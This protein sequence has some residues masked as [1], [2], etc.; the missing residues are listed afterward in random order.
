M[1]FLAGTA[2]GAYIAAHAVAIFFTAASLFV[3]YAMRPGKPKT[4]SGA[5]TDPARGIKL[6]T[7]ETSAPV[8]VLY[9][10]NKIGGNDVFIETVGTDN[11]AVWIVQGMGE[12][13]I[14]GVQT[15][16]LNDKL[17]TEYGSL[18]DYWEHLGTSDQT[19]DA[20]LT[21]AIAKFTDPMR[22]AAYLV[23]KLQFDADYFQGLPERQV[24]VRGRKLYDFRDESTAYSTNHVL[25]LYDYMTNTRYGLGIAAAKIDTDSWE[26]V[27]N[28]IDAKGW[29][30]HYAVTADMT[31][32]DVIDT[33]LTHF[34][35]EM[36][37]WDGKYYLRYADLNE[38]AIAMTIDDEQIA[39]D[40]DGRALVSISQPSTFGTADGYRVKFI[41]PDKNYTEDSLIV[42]DALGTIKDFQ[43]HGCRDRETAG[44]L[45]TY[46]LEREQLSRTISGTFRDDCLQLEP[47]DLVTFTSSALS[48]SEQTMRVTQADIRPDGLIDLV[49]EYEDEDLYDD[50]YNITAD[51]VYTCTLPDPAS[52]PPS[53]GNVQVSEEQYNYRL[54]T[55]TRMNIT[56]DAPANYPWYS[57]CEVWRSFDNVT[58][59]YLYN[60]NTDFAVD[61]VEEGVTY[62][63]RL[64]AVSIWGTK[65]QDNND[66]KISLTIQGYQTVP[67]SLSSLKAVVNANSVNL[68]ATKVSDP[69]VEIYEFRLGSS[70]SGSIF[71]SALRAPNLSLYGVKPGT[72]TFWCNTLSNN[73]FYGATP[74]SATV[75]LPEP[76]TGWS[77]DTTET[78]DYAAVGED[79]DN[80][81]QVEYTGDDY[82]KCSH[83]GG[84]LVGTYTSPIYDLGAVGD[85]LVYL[86]ADIVITG[87]GTDWDSIAPSPTT[88][89]D[90]SAETSTWVELMEL[91]TGP[92]VSMKM[93]YGDTSPPTSEVERMEVLSTV[94]SGRYFQIEITITDPQINV[95]ALVE[96]FALNF[97][98][99]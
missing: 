75:Y 58:Y 51:D 5:Q 43:L 7:R 92:Q 95:N 45:G 32:Q 63:I 89:A 46:Y 26:E 9:G 44:I 57:H 34:R 10:E 19:V 21:A 79:H 3:A 87:A 6:N 94:V 84:V 65:Q 81:E 61:P 97:A 36:V 80:T 31:A 90:I 1:P 41:D 62:Y 29:E 78:C 28:Y 37:W 13:E 2:V 39:Q 67:A 53:V 49:L 8:T 98:T 52:E 40:D 38:E 54:R 22:Y 48:I 72:H 42:G 20:N 93:Y 27:A 33:I 76:P 71:L 18:V 55:F 70:W 86:V 24:I 30:F 11:D 59:E 60:V 68:Q 47:H 16:Y 66:Y 35:G 64:K 96:N 74:R 23:W 82:L 99:Q 15:L 83:G 88:W 73:G 69:D 25:A 56:F 85:Y 91:P 77:I 14:E 12:G 17:Y 50:E 4:G